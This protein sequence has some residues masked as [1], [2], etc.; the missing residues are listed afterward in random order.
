MEDIAQTRDCPILLLALARDGRPLWLSEWCVSELV[1]FLHFVG[2]ASRISKISNWHILLTGLSQVG[3]YERKR[4]VHRFSI[5]M[6]ML[7]IIR[8]LFS[9]DHNFLA[10]FITYVVML[11]VCPI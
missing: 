3:E 8:V 4:K 2:Y 5:A 11:L 9:W 10:K 6:W 7:L 1:I